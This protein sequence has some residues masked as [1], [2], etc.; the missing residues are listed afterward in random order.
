MGVALERGGTGQAPRRGPAPG[1]PARLRSAL[2]VRGWT[3]AAEPRIRFGQSILPGVAA[4]GPADHA[5]AEDFLATA[6]AVRDGRF[7]YLGHEIVMRDGVD[8]FPRGASERWVAAH[9]RLEPLLALGVA[10][11]VSSEPH[12]RRG[13]Y[14]VANRLAGSWVDG[15]RGGTGPAWGLEALSR[16]VVN[17]LHFHQLFATEVRD[18]VEF[19]RKLLCSLYAQ[20]EYLAGSIPRAESDPWLA[21]AGRALVLAGRVFDGLEARTWIEQ[22]TAI[23]WD[24]LRE[25]VN[26]DGGEALR[27]PVWQR[28]LLAEYLELLAVMKAGN[29][30][31]P[32]WARKRV[33]GMAD[34]LCRVSHPNGD[35][36][37]FSDPPVVGIRPS[38]E[39]LAVA[40]VVLGEPQ[41]ALAADL[42]AIWPRLMLG[43]TGIK[44]QQVEGAERP[45]FGES[46]AL[47]RTGFY[48]L[49]GTPGDAMILDG[50]APGGRG[51]G[52]YE[53]S[54]GGVPVVVGAGFADGE[55]WHAPYFRSE[56]A[57]NVLVSKANG[58]G[59]GGT[60]QTEPNAHWM[61]RDGLVSFLA[62]WGDRRRLVLNLPGRFWLVIDQVNG[63]GPWAGES[64][65]HLDP[66]CRVEAVCQ[67]RP[68]LLVSRP[69]GAR[70]ALAFA[71]ST[72]V[73]LVGG[74]NVPRPQGWTA[75]TP[76]RIDAAYTVVLPVA[77]TRPLVCGY[78]IVP[79]GTAD[80]ALSLDGESL[81]VRA[82]L[83]IARTEYQLG[84]LQDEIELRSGVA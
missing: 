34:F 46:R 56:G 43:T 28:A 13:W 19:R 75:R 31:I 71:G 52:A 17:L 63:T 24:Q 11:L 68:T 16:R 78:A 30:E 42:R 64:F 48:V 26:E 29:D 54:V 76:G 84:V 36:A 69:P 32:A 67:G 12:E 50:G 3:R 35:V 79:R 70:F 74:V 80:V 2:A 14:G 25:R 60:A 81:E 22:G 61:L 37:L 21:A 40:S 27:S 82:T 15:V 5:L 77:G 6:S 51:H 73:R 39:L 66:A 53:L 55:A 72:D 58:S 65:I 59:F 44:V 62:T 47:R 57:Q 20:T 18:D 23:V 4:I 9:H 49:A 38:Q 41:L 45:T 83:R 1:L 8:W 33:R 7:A 10:A